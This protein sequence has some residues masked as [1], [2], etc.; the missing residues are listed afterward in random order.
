MST[1]I[2]NLVIKTPLA[3]TEPKEIPKETQLMTTLITTYVDIEMDKEGN[4]TILAETPLVDVINPNPR[5]EPFMV[6]VTAEA[7]L[8]FPPPGI[9]WTE[10]PEES[11]KA[12]SKCPK[13]ATDMLIG[14]I[15]QDTVEA[16]KGHLRCS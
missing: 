12:P 8:Q 1:L 6:Q 9:P 15:T 11:K 10:Q 16:V 7:L 3:E 2:N 5:T 4:T 14:M 13:L